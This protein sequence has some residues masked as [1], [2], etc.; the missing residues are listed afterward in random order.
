MDNDYLMKNIQESAELYA[1]RRRREP[2]PSVTDF[3]KRM[4]AR[5]RNPKASTSDPSDTSVHPRDYQNR[6]QAMEGDL[7]ADNSDDDAPIFADNDDADDD[8]ADADDDLPEYASD[9]DNL[10]DDSADDVV[11]VNPFDD[12]GDDQNRVKMDEFERIML[13][14]LYQARFNGTNI[15]TEKMARL[16]N[17]LQ[18][19]VNP[20]LRCRTCSCRTKPAKPKPLFSSSRWDT[21]IKQVPRPFNPTI[22]K[23]FYGN[24]GEL[25]KVKDLNESAT[26]KHRHEECTILPRDKLKSGQ[27][28]KFFCYVSLRAWLRHQIP[29]LYDKL[30]FF[31]QDEEKEAKVFHDLSDCDRYKH[32]AT[33]ADGVP[34]ITLTLAWDGV[35]YSED[36]SKTM[37]PLCAYINELP[38]SVRINN[39]MVIAVQAGKHKPTSDIMLRPLIGELEKLNITPI[40]IEIKEGIFQS[41]RVRLLLILADA[42]A[43]AQTLNC[44]QFNAYNGIN[45]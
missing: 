17:G 25:V 27:N 26:C 40:E 1:K 30:K 15:A 11:Y 43:R 8:A 5:L 16:I 34:V 31:D 4:I 28:A 21:L 39:P 19:P 3:A 44:N 35:S 32:L 33:P 41:F 24:C 12:I 38:Y 7:S 36:A 42:P 29:V 14:L 13:L 37:W 22:R 6:N 10:D 2:D 20:C 9:T 23:Y 18:E 45:L